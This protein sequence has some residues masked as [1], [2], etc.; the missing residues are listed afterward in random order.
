MKVS[1]LN[2]LL[3]GER[4]GSDSVYAG[5]AHCVPS[6]G[7]P[8]ACHRRAKNSLAIPI[9]R[10]THRGTRPRATSSALNCISYVLRGVRPARVLSEEACRASDNGWAAGTAGNLCYSVP[11]LRDT[12]G[13]A[14]D[15][16]YLSIIITTNF[17]LLLFLVL[18]VASVA[19]RAVSKRPG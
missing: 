16:F 14:L 13:S 17:H 15:A 4:S 11:T 3:G 1:L 12:C 6:E 8:A 19:P 5:H 7:V 2:L 9:N 10:I 18:T